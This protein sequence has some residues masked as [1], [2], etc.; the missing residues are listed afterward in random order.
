MTRQT[1]GMAEIG[2]SFDDA[3]GCDLTVAAKGDHAPQF[4]AQCLQLSD[5]ALYRVEMLLRDRIDSGAGLVRFVRQLDQ[6]P[7][8]IERK[9][10]VA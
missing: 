9:A 1:V 7:N 3:A 4:L 10:K 6:R 8:R 5:A 2:Q